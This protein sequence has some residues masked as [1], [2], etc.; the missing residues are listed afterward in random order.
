MG[1]PLEAFVFVVGVPL[2]VIVFVVSVRP[3]SVDPWDILTRS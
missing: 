2:E 3:R 1:G